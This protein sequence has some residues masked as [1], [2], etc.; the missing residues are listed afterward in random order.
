MARDGAKVCF[1]GL[2]LTLPGVAYAQDAVRPDAGVTLELT[3]RRP[4]EALLA[5]IQADPEVWSVTP[6]EDAGRIRVVCAGTEEVRERLVEACGALQAGLVE[7]RE[8]SQVE[9][10][11]DLFA[12]RPRGR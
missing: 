6:Q 4:S 5:R 8:I 3:L 7:F 10:A 12:E 2:A 1:V 11:A 9:A